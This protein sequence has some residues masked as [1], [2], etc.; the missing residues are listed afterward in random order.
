MNTSFAERLRYA[1]QEANMSQAALA[2][3]T[4]ISKSGVNQYLSG[5]NAPSTERIRMIADAVGV[6]TEYLTGSSG[7]TQPEP[8]PLIMKIGVRKAARCM[9]KSENF[10][11][12]GIQKGLLPFG[13]AVPGIGECWNY[14]INPAKLRDFVGADRFDSF[15]GLV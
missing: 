5:K 2:R 4:G 10:V 13:T 15:F 14:Y 12:I 1:M 6:T 11:R 3:E 7:D 9:R 8:R